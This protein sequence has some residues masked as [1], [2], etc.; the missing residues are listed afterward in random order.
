MIV[1]NYYLNFIW[2]STGVKHSPLVLLLYDK[3]FVCFALLVTCL[4]IKIVLDM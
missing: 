3:S 4:E 1:S 2:E